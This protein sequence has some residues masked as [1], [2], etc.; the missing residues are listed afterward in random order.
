MFIM[1]VKSITRA[2]IT[3]CINDKEYMHY[4]L[5]DSTLHVM[6]LLRLTLIS[7]YSFKIYFIQFEF[8][9]HSTSY[10]KH[11]SYAMILCS[12]IVT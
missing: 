9:G 10:I 2:G 5:T 1:K 12:H 11:L 7:L 3:Y 4:L 8:K 6:G